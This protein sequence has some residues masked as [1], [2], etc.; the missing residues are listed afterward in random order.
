MTW[1]LLLRSL[2]HW[3]ASVSEPSCMKPYSTDADSGAPTP[4]IQGADSSFDTDQ[5]HYSAHVFLPTA[6]Q[7]ELDEHP[8]M[9]ES[10][11]HLPVRPDRHDEIDERYS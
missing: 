6:P 4:A 7:T 2:L 9:E 11:P 10:M 5:N 3:R 8:P 1:A